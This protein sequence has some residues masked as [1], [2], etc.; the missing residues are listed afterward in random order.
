M[1]LVIR[2]TPLLDTHPVVGLWI[3]RI[4]ELSA[5]RVRPATDTEQCTTAEAPHNITAARSALA[6]GQLPGH[7]PW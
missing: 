3:R 7:R 5:R 2:R 4:P 1:L 6:Q